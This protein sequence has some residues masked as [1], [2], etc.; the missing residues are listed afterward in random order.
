MKH[1]RICPNIEFA[2]LYKEALSTLYSNINIYSD[3][4]NKIYVI[5][6]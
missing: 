2:N 4:F 6:E 5:Y 3:Y 1:Y